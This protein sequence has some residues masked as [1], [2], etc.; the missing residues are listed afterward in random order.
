MIHSSYRHL[1]NVARLLN[2][3]LSI[4]LSIGKIELNLEHIDQ[5]ITV[6]PDSSLS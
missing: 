6:G 5:R 3:K 2:H 1:I 4:N